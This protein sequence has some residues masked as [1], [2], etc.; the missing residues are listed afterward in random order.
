MPQEPN[1]EEKK[2]SE[3]MVA[4]DREAYRRE[5]E[6]IR[7]DEYRKLD[8]LQSELLEKLRRQENLLEETG[9]ELEKAE[10]EFKAASV[11]LDAARRQHDLTRFEFADLRSQVDAIQERR[12]RLCAPQLVGFVDELWKAFDSIRSKTTAYERVK[13]EP[14]TGKRT[15]IFLT[16]APAVD[17]AL[18]AIRGV[19]DQAEELRSQPLTDAEIETAIERLRT[20]IPDAI[21]VSREEERID[22]APVIISE[23]SPVR[24]A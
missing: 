13:T 19:I 7:L 11:K 4:R 2:I 24:Y 14:I 15:S 21:E 17:A 16:N 10:A 9:N 6:R 18:K 5:A 12:R 3:W 22:F 1:S 23:P 20:S 8:D